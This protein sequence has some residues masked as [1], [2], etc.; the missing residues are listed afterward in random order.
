[1]ERVSYTGQPTAFKWLDGTNV[2]DT[3]NNFAFGEPNN[4]QGDEDCG[5]FFTNTGLWRSEQC[6]PQF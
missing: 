3:Y 6:Q 2:R 1:M 4:P 5:I